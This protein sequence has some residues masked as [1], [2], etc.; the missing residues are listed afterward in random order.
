LAYNIT[1]EPTFL[2][3]ILLK[4]LVG[5]RINVKLYTGS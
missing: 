2:L 5:K 1:N 4:V 3:E